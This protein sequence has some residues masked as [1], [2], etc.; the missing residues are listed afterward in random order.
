MP[1]FIHS[2]LCY[3]LS[4]TLTVTVSSLLGLASIATLYCFVS[5]GLLARPAMLSAII[6]LGSPGTLASINK[7]RD[8]L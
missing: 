1:L 6:R 4:V 2:A 3:G 8:M 5:V 7:L